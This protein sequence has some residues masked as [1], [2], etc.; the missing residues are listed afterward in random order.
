MLFEHSGE[1]EVSQP[2]LDHGATRGWV[3]ST[4]PQSLYF[5]EGDPITI[6]QEAGWVLKISPP[7]RFKP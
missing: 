2:V 3:V 7:N 5:Q 1:A 4:M 6:I